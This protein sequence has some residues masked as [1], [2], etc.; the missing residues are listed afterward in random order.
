MIPERMPENRGALEARAMPRHR[1]R[2]TRNTTNPEERSL[3]R[4][5]DGSAELAGILD[6]LCKKSL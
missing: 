6:E 3:V 4:L 5:L 2:A 1:G